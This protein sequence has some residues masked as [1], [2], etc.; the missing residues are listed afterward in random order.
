MISSGDNSLS[1]KYECVCKSQI[2][3]Q[4]IFY[5]ITKAPVGLNFP[6]GAWVQRERSG[7]TQ[8]LVICLKLIA[9]NNEIEKTLIPVHEQH[10]PLKI[11]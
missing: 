2:H 5:I 10:A 4:M 3:I 9:V 8:G 1:E 11:Y 7:V 6:A